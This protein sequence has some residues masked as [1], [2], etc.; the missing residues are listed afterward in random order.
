MRVLARQYRR[1]WRT[2]GH[3]PW[4][5]VLML[6]LLLAHIPAHP[7]AAV[8]DATVQQCTEAGLDAALAATA[9]GGTIFFACGGPATITII[10]TKQVTVSRRITGNRLI[11]LSGG[12]AV[13]VLS[14]AAG[15]NLIL[16]GL[17]ISDGR[18][19]GDFG[20]GVLNRG[21][22]EI[23][24]VAFTN[25]QANSGG[26]IYNSGV[27]TITAS[28]FRDNTASANGG[29][30]VNAGTG[31]MQIS[32]STFSASSA[33]VLGGA[34][35]NTGTINLSNSSL[36]G[37]Q[38]SFGGAIESLS[39]SI[40]I[41]N[42]AIGDNHT[43][44][45]GG[46]IQNQG[47]LSIVGSTISGNSADGIAGGLQ[48]SGSLAL[49][50]STISGNRARQH[51]GGIANLG[52]LSLNN[53]TIANNSADAN[54]D[55]SGDGGGIFTN[56]GSSITLK[57][58][59]LA[60]NV[61]RGGQAPDCAGVLTSQANNMIQQ[62]AGCTIV[63][64][65]TG[66]ITGLDPL[67]GPLAD[68]GGATLTQALLPGSPA[69]DAGGSTTCAFTDQRGVGRPVGAGCDIGAYELGFV[70]NSAEDAPDANPADRA[71]ATPAG[72]GVCTLRAAIQ[73]T[74]ALLVL[75]AITF[76]ITSPITLSITGAGG[77]AAVGDLDITDDLIIT[78]LGQNQ[79][80]ID[81]GNSAA[82]GG[83]LHVAATASVTISGVT[84][85]HGN[86]G[87]NTYGGGI[88]NEGT[89]TLRNSS[90]SENG[91]ASGGGIANFG[92]LT[93][94]NSAIDGNRAS[95]NG[96]GIYNRYDPN[97]N[98]S[99][100][101]AA[102]LDSTIS[103]NRAEGVLSSGGGIDNQSVATLTNV[104]ISGNAAA[105]DGGG[106]RV[107]S[108]DPA[109]L[110]L[111]NVTIADNTADSDDD[112]TGDG[113][114]M[115]NS[116]GGI[117]SFK[118]TIVAENTD[119]SG[120]APDCTGGATAQGPNMV[121]LGYNLVG[122]NARCAIAIK[123]GDRI[124]TGANPI[125]PRLASLQGASSAVRTHRPLSGSPA[126]NAGSPALPGGQGSACAATDQRGLARPQG[127]ACDI[128]ASEAILADL[129]I[130]QSVSRNPAAVGGDLTYTIR[131]ENRGPSGTAGV[132]MIG[133]LPPQVDLR[134]A[135]P[136]Q[137]QCDG[138]R[139]ITCQ[140]GSLAQGGS[141]LISLTV[142]PRTVGLFTIGVS[143]SAAETDP[144]L[145]DNSA[146]TSEL[147]TYL[148]YLP[149]IAR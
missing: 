35:F 20:G 92:L 17:T 2:V 74:N 28:M 68:N 142:R 117:V 42:S 81:G 114:G 128:G 102:V 131:V 108:T 96:G 83:V 63:G 97:I 46:G 110:Q 75:E 135:I 147:A 56:A 8:A 111:N 86:A 15:A 58:T 107:F 134:S 149:A 146:S 100:G 24:D 47:T 6:G 141:A 72:N 19:D 33:G 48:N 143:V 61:D 62:L 80:I 121:S 4:A 85:R 26:A 89:L 70:V 127:A 133:T 18:A 138:T 25:N 130:A 148:L 132:T 43:S 22:L 78:G 82:V 57:N 5:G 76:A 54:G 3:W 38:A 44:Q 52:T 98:S 34:I 29:S 129:Q 53:A 64:D 115:A 88:R 1:F 59:L 136:S 137:G 105:Q 125:D 45:D 116:A 50:N 14:V 109:A 40:T 99:G 106:I 126:V 65:P 145:A 91:A 13:P 118:N 49:T 113:G 9:A 79:T 94:A 51:G 140:L 32:G 84:I 41:T 10:S 7:A 112:G 67:L 23:D 93:I 37:N 11:T 124:G 90:M 71:C 77:D 119:R 27:V 73:Q 122:N 139:T 87:A 12:G 144:R 123:S 69:V 66:N 30:V 95:S 60:Q 31:H 39:G 104:T 21:T 120:Q 36:G 101:R 103:G 16:D 55:G